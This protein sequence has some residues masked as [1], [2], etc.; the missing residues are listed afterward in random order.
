MKKSVHFSETVQVFHIP[1]DE[2]RL[3]D[4]TS[5][6]FKIK[7]ANVEKLLK[8]VLQLHLVSINNDAKEGTSYHS[9][10]QTTGSDKA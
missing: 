1:I 9:H 6:H 10:L 7:I 8:H 4:T 5:V 2:D 3:P